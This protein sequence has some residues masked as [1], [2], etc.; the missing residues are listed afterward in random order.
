MLS[1]KLFGYFFPYANQFWKY[2]SW[3]PSAETE[4]QS[5]NRKLDMAPSTR[6][7]LAVMGQ[8]PALNIAE[9]EYP[10]SFYNRTTSKVE[11]AM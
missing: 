8:N 4:I 6:I 5:L 11:R 9:K 10:I 3:F 7:G 2:D 1:S